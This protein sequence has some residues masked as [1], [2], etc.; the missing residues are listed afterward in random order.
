L[1]LR[2]IKEKQE[3]EVVIDYIESRGDDTARI[4]SCLTFVPR[5]KIGERVKVR[6]QGVSEKFALARRVV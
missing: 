2:P 1:Q 4:Q 6:I 3:I 5:S